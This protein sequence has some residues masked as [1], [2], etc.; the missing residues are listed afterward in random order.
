MKKHSFTLVELMIIIAIITLV[1]SVLISLIRNPKILT[2]RNLVTIELSHSI[3]PDPSGYVVDTIN[4]L[5]SATRLQIETICSNLDPI[6]QVA[7]C[8]INTTGSLS[9]EEY[10]IKLAE[11]W[12][13]GY[14]GKDNGIILILAK[15]D[16]KVR[17][18]IGR[19]LEPII[20]DAKAGTI[21]DSDVIPYFKQDQYAQ[22]LLSGVQAIEKIL[23]E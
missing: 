3:F 11:K 8:I 16:R 7:V 19:G 17:I 22:G 9:I 21:L 15:T 13:S 12:E 5:D 6:A 20:N 18:E 1:A 14:A 23:R 4:L 2:S 10:G